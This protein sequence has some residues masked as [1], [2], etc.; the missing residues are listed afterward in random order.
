M[1]QAMFV[2]EAHDLTKEYRDGSAVVRALRGVS[3]SMDRGQVVSL[4]GRSGSGKTTLLS[5]L[6]CILTPTSGTITIDGQAVDARRP[7]DLSRIRKRSIGFV[8]QHYNLI[9]SLTARENVEYALNIRGHR[10]RA[11]RREAQRVIDLVGLSDRAHALPADLSGGEK[12]RVAIARAVAG[13]A[14]LLLADEP[15]ANLD[16]ENGQ[17][18][19]AL[20]RDL[21]RNEGRAALIVTH[22][23]K[24]RNIADRVL[25]IADG[26]L[27]TD[28]ATT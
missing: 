12:Q 11:A 5:I 14:P 17:A 8:F 19:L 1:N 24:V 18:V 3:L 4:E 15:T 27:S 20:L 2:L 26:V 21:A 13:N 6:G 25:R 16:S 7:T 22:D 28:E 9:P 10:G 23:P